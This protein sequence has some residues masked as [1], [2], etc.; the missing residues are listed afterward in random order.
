MKGSLSGAA[1]SAVELLS[2]TQPI[3]RR[4]AADGT[5]TQAPL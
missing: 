2:G 3:A 5:A 1:T 4:Y